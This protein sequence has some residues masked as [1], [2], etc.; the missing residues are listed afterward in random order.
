[1]LV[2]TP[3]FVTYWTPNFDIITRPEGADDFVGC[4]RNV[5]HGRRPTP[6]LSSSPSI[7]VSS[8][9]LTTEHL[10]ALI[11]SPSGIHS[12][13]HSQ[14]H[15]RAPSPRLAWLPSIFRPRSETPS[16]LEDPIADSE[17]DKLML[18]ADSY[19]KANSYY[20]SPSQ[21]LGDDDPETF[22]FSHKIGIAYNQL[23]YFRKA[24][25]CF[26][27]AFAGRARVLGDEDPQTLDSLH[28]LGLTIYHQALSRQLPASPPPQPSLDLSD[29]LHHLEL[30]FQ[31][32]SK[33]LGDSHPDT[34]AS[35]HSVG[36][37]LRRLHRLSAAQECFSRAVLGRESVL[38]PEARDTLDS[39][40]ELGRTCYHSRDHAGARLHL[41]RCLDARKRVLGDE[42]PA[43]LT[44]LH[45]LGVTYVESYEPARGRECLRRAYETRVKTLGEEHED[46]RESFTVMESLLML[47]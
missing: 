45:Y 29:A 4:G 30:A 18:E 6:K 11:D 47:W 5:S 17:L 31:G 22:A 26:E 9:E 43:T 3:S 10:T 41:E 33:T 15:S 38:G 8:P 37:I 19:W 2:E 16:T 13:A 1:M 20:S 46:S 28:W 14:V 7:D 21:T 40:H 25:E 12:Q 42:D 32:R 24:R 23:K 39:L 27:S 36:L 34:L 35:L 44:T